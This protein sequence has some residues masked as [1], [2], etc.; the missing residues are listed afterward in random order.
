M[1]SFAF[2]VPFAFFALCTPMMIFYPYFDLENMIPIGIILGVAGVIHLGWL[3]LLFMFLKQINN[4]VSRF[5]WA[6]ISTLAVGIFPMVIFTIL[7]L[8]GEIF[9][10]NWID[11][12]ILFTFSAWIPAS[13]IG[14][15]IFGKVLQSGEKRAAGIGKRGAR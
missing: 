2:A 1:I 9:H 14:G 5:N 10:E 13:L 4:S 11:K 3:N 8:S 12:D 15:W 6:R 7:L